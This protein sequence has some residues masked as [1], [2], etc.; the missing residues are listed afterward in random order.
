VVD[1]LHVERLSELVPAARLPAREASKEPM[2][3][4]NTTR[5]AVVVVEWTNNQEVLALLDYFLTLIGQLRE[6]PMLVLLPYVGER[7]RLK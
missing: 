6:E 3:S 1:A 7:F 2:P 4:I 5:W